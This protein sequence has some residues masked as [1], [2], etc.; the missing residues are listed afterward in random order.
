MKLPELKSL[1]DKM[2]LPISY[3]EWQPG[4]VPELPY[5]LYYEKSTSNFLADNTVYCKK[6]DFV[7]ELYTNTKNIREENR[8]EEL[9]IKAKLPFESYETYLSSE[10]MYLKAYEITI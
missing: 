3:R 4:Q 2:N 9:F 6:T 10:Q 5:L 1:L 7:V 8:L